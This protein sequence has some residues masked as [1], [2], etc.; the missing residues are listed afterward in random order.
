MFLIKRLVKQGVRDC[1]RGARV[2]SLRATSE[3]EG[4]IR[5]VKMKGRTSKVNWKKVDE[6]VKR[7][8]AANA[9]KATRQ[10]NE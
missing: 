4:D 10:E 7:Q 5:D 9:D 3:N 2:P 1:P 8:S 6:R